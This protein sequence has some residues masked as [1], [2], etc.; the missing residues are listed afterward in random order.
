VVQGAGIVE[1]ANVIAIIG[2]NGEG[3][4][5][6]Q[7]DQSGI[8]VGETYTLIGPTVGVNDGKDRGLRFNWSTGNFARSGFFG[9]DD[10]TGY[11]TFRPIAT[12][13]NEVVTGP[14]G[15]MQANIFRG[16]LI[17]D[18][19]TVS[20]GLTVVGDALLQPG[21]GK[22]LIINPTA[23]G[24][25]DNTAIGFTT[26]STG[27]FTALTAN[28]SV[29]LTSTTESNDPVTGALV[30]T[31]GTGIGGNTYVGGNL[32]V[33]GLLSVGGN[34]LFGGALTVP[35]GGSGNTT[36]T[37]KGIL[38]GN[39][40]DP[41]QVTAASSPSSNANTGYAI[42]TTDID[43]IPVWTNEIDGGAF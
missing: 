13:N 22:V 32:N 15:D 19:T 16:N 18:T 21:A 20:T 38:Y 42:L 6:V 29:T 43:E 37:S 24:N 2:L 10:S 17:S 33:D 41:I 28:A 11:F 35:N 14:L 12:F 27:A 40:V 30:V 4:Y 5:V 1:F 26:R 8:I 25:I 3:N 7:I 34:I 31:G 23:V 36:F 9:F 39:G